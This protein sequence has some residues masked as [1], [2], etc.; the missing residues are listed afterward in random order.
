LSSAPYF[1]VLAAGRDEW[2]FVVADVSGKGAGAA[3]LMANL[4]AIVRTCPLDRGLLETAALIN[5]HVSGLMRQARYITAIL[6]RYEPSTRTLRCVNAG[7]CGGVLVRRDGEVERIESTGV[8]LGLFESASWE[9]QRVV[10]DLGSILVL[11]TDGI[12]ERENS[13]GEC[14]GEE[15]LLKTV[16]KHAPHP[17]S[18]VLRG[19][20]D[21]NDRFA[22]GVPPADDS[23]L[24]IVR[25]VPCDPGH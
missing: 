13:A 2:A 12:T 22:G 8:P 14:Y 16:L 11:Y 23:T 6:A 20:L 7:H 21:D 25:A 24:L 1:D 15:R 17:S 19:V 9:V 18:R 4:H 10:M 3:L 5:G